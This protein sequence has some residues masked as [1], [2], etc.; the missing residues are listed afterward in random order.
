MIRQR[1]RGRREVGDENDTQISQNPNEWAKPSEEV[2]EHLEP[3]VMEMTQFDQSSPQNAFKSTQ[4]FFSPCNSYS[5][6]RI[7]KTRG[8][9]THW[10]WHAR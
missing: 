8:T 1:E 10:K 2:V 6:P 3:I 7:G 9:H 5:I 4:I